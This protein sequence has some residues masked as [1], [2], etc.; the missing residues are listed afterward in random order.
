[1]VPPSAATVYY[2]G[3]PRF[4][5]AAFDLFALCLRGS[6]PASSEEGF[7]PR[8]SPLLSICCPSKCLSSAGSLLTVLVEDCTI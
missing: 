8:T 5:R 3:Y 4:R 1:M 2:A 6:L 7:S